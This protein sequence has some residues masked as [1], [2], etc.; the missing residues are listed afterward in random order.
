MTKR[1]DL[2]LLWAVGAVLTAPT[3]AAASP[4]HFELRWSAPAGCPDRDDARA[5]IDKALGASPS[6]QH[7]AMVVRVTIGEVA[8][9]RWSADIWMYG[10]AG[11]G[12]RSVEAASCAQVAEAATLIVALAIAVNPNVPDQA[13]KTA[14][15][16]TPAAI[17]FGVHARAL[18]DVGSLPHPNLGI[19][20]ALTL[21][22]GRLHAEAE[23]SGWLPRHAYDD[24]SAVSGG[25][26]S[27]L[28][29]G[30]RGCA[31][32]L[33]AAPSGGFAFGPCAAVESGATIG[34]GF[35]LAVHRV[36]AEYWGA[37]MLGL[38]A[39]YA[40]ASPLSLDLLAEVGLPWHRPTWQVD[41]VGPVF[42]PRAFF[43]R[44]SFGVGWTFP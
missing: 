30:L 39:R 1:I 8:P 15:G 25:K 12:E 32:L 33:L 34:Q 43:G 4:A 14:A 16:A 24:A 5:A 36:R 19:G 23:V 31:D 38:S 11:S 28:A 27:I 18:G 3:V 29:G 7:P 17:V 20:L 6:D 40:S 26:F 13:S 35:G 9:Q 2:A 22:S 37:G 44:I 42:R 10:A 21:Q 41:D